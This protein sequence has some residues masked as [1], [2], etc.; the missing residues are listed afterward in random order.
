MKKRTENKKTDLL[1]TKLSHNVKFPKIISKKDVEEISAKVSKNKKEVKAILHAAKKYFAAK[2]TI[3]KAA[4]KAPGT[5]G[6][7]PMRKK[8]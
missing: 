6:P 2:K 8:R 4:R 3:S 5:G 1:K 7:G